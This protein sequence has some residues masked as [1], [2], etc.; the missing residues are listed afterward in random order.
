LR[1]DKAEQDALFSDVLIPVTSFFRDP[2]IFQT[3]TETI[4]P[5]ILKNKPSDEAIRIWIAGCSTGE[6]AYSIAICLHEFLGEKLFHTK[7]QIFASDISH[8]AIKKARVAIY[9]KAEVEILSAIQIKNYFVKN[10]NGYEVNKL[11]RD[12]CVFAPHNFLKDPPFAKMDLIT[13][14]NV[15]IYMDTFL[16]KKAFTTFH[17]A[18]KE[19]G[20]LLLGKSETT[21]ASSH[22][23]T[24]VEK[25]EKI[26]SRKPVQSRLV[27]AAINR[28]EEFLVVKDKTASKQE[29]TQTDFR[30]SAEEIMILKSPASV[31]V[32][33]AM[34]IV[35]IHGD[36][37]PFLQPPQGKPTHNL[38][39]M[40]REGLAFELRNAIHKATKEKTEVTKENI[41]VKTN[42]KQ[43]LAT[44]E[45]IPLTDTVEPHFLIRFEEKI[46]P[47]VREEKKS[48]S[49]TVKETRKQNEQL[50]KELSQ[51]REDMRSITEDMEA[52]NEELQSANEE[53]QSS[54][55][56]MQ[57]LNEEL[58]TSKEELQSTNEELII[59]NQELLDKQEQLNAAY[60]AQV[61]ARKQ[62][63]ASEK[64]QKKLA[65]QL[66]L[67]TDSA[68][69]G[70]GSLNV[71]TE[72]LE[73]SG[74]MKK[75]WGYSEHLD[76]LTLEDWIKSILPEDKAL[77]FQKI[78]ESKNN[79]SIYDAEYRIKRANDGTIVW[80]K[81]IGEH[82]Y[83][84]FG[85]AITLT[86]INLDITEQKETEE[87]IRQS[88]ALFKS[89]FDSSLAAIVV[90]DNQGNYF[91]ANKAASKLFG[92]TVK[93]LLQ[94]NVGDLKTT[95]KAGAAKRFEEYLHKGEEADEFDFIT[96]NGTHKFVQY[97]AIRIKTDFHLSIM[98][99]ITEQ[100]LAEDQIR[101][102]NASLEEKVKT[103]TQ[104]LSKRNI[105]L[106]NANAELASFNYVASHDLQEPLRKIQGFSK[107]ILDKDGDKLSDT[108]KDYFNRITSAAKRMQN[109]I[110]SLI[111]FSQTNSGEI[112][113][114]KTDLNQTLIEVQ[115]VLND[116]ITQKNAVIES[117][118][119]PTLNAVPVQMQQLFSNLIGNALK[120]SK[121]DVAPL[122]KITAEKVSINEIS[123]QIKQN[124]K[125]WKITISD[126]G[127]GF[128][129][130]YES[131]IFE[132][133]QRLHGKTEYE[134]T[135]IGLAICKKIVQLHSGTI[136]ATGEPNVGAI[137]TF[138]LSDGNKS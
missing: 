102:L 97:Q 82:Q 101:L 128:E 83:D 1:T 51:T 41:P 90:T 115:N 3:L 107:R 28:K 105:Q 56:E 53:L 30:K 38:L 40:A 22:L 13:C 15:L 68:K 87:Q 63:E 114:E 109:L 49:G 91:S 35:H 23:F 123:G 113:F 50:E 120:Y 76:N 55:E 93:E 54:N 4:F 14:R 29:V 137:F 17:Y 119:L 96:K 116:S 10:N 95:A 79:R 138:F 16:Q 118:S 45:V 86:G 88:E 58:E 117:E 20:F 8:K 78:E 70:I 67:A 127:I 110:E 2:K 5:A 7:I 64:E 108:T 74:L 75:M 37:T 77:A 44:I 52:A 89:I 19:N 12:M 132:V 99:D 73:W 106:E 59:V 42:D 11:I 32:N 126:N 92:Y 121:P 71:K 72:K 43:S 112:V 31:V 27:Y 25:H 21:G 100:K 62:I 26:Y 81:S 84:E 80:M 9:T 94:M 36:I 60:A 98:M 85:E 47:F 48:S 66:K 103:R 134:G 46:I 135:G 125:F 122:I 136:T 69:V 61:E 111:S 104:E 39:K 65:S 124:N 6:E 34:D 33:E 57:S 130:K 133:F 129:Q 131:K 18:L 24:Q